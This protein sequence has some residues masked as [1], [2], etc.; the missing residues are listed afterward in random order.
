M[1]DNADFVK[2]FSE[3]L[4]LSGHESVAVSTRAAVVEAVARERPDVVLLD[5]SLP[6]YEKAKPWEPEAESLGVPTVI[7]TGLPLP[8]DVPPNVPVLKKPANSA[9]LIG[10]LEA[11][12]GKWA[13]GQST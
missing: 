6:D 13:T 1:D 8:S 12:A 10:I 7:L 9:E 3:A 5:L 11:T 4:E 2:K